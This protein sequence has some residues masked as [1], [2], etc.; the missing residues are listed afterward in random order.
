MSATMKG[1][2]VEVFKAATGP[3]CTGGGASSRHAEFVI[4][5]DA[6]PGPFAP[7]PSRPALRLVR[8]NLHDG[9]YIHAVPDEPRP[10]GAAGPMF[11]GNFVFSCDSR[12][13]A[14][15]NYPIPVHDRYEVQS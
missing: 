1:L 13:R 12:F 6:M 3:D 2:I 7:T 15:T 11:G 9:E 5:D 8:R 10:A 14:V 4:L